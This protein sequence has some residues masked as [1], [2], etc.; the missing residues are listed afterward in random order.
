MKESGKR[1][2]KSLR[3]RE[4]G[5]KKKDGIDLLIRIAVSSL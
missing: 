5:Q 1:R 3:G 4:K 2:G